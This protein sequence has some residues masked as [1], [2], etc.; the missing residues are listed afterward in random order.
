MVVVPYTFKDGLHIPAG[1]QIAFCSQQQN[2][3]PDIYPDADEF[4]PTRWLRQRQDIDQNRFHFPS[5]TDDWLNWGSGT[6][7]C[8][9]RFLADV[10]LKLI[11]VHLLTHFDIKYPSEDQHRP[12]DGAKNFMILPDMTAPLMFKERD[13]E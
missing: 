11:F 9:G 1:M 7:A 6:H 4:D 2:V 8:P 12:A 13:I 3:D 5:T 10:S